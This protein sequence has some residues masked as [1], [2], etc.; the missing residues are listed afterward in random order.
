M[1]KWTK[2]LIGVVITMALL[3]VVGVFSYKYYEKEQESTYVAEQEAI[4]SIV[5]ENIKT[6]EKGL[7]EA[8]IQE[9]FLKSGV[10]GDTLREY[11]DQITQI[12]TDIDKVVPINEEMSTR[13]AQLRTA[14]QELERIFKDIQSRFEAYLAVNRVFTGAK[15]VGD[16]M[17][18]NVGV[19]EEVTPKQLDEVRAGIDLPDGDPLRALIEE[20][21]ESGKA[22]LVLYQ[23][24]TEQMAKLSELSTEEIDALAEKI[25]GLNNTDLLN[26]LVIN[27][28]RVVQRELKGEVDKLF[29]DGTPRDDISQDVI[30]LLYE[31][32]GA[33]QEVEYRE[34]LIGRIKEVI[35]ASE[36]TEPNLASAEEAEESQAEEAE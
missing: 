14:C 3:S 31:K 22:D 7:K 33:I 4:Y 27:I 23:E 26:R 17:D 24:I 11:H 6:V 30:D 1:S 20:A 12:H 16:A 35:V 32:V 8:Y 36:L 28:D 21:L 29:E 5:E 10:T 34:E 2:V 9:A 18:P 13:Q 19:K 25:K 15:V